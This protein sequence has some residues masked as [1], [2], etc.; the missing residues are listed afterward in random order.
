MR[1]SDWSSDVCSSDL[2][3]AGAGIH[4]EQDAL[5]VDHRLDVEMAVTA[6]AERHP[7]LADDLAL[8]RQQLAGDEG[9]QRADLV[10]V[11]VADNRSEERSVGKGCVRTGRSRWWP[12]HEEKKK[13]RTNK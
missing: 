8:G 11:A 6:G 1:I 2:H 3:V 10:A 7:V 4:Q 5:A 12:A 9:C 13:T